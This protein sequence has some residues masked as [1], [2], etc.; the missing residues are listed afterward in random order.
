MA[1]FLNQDYN[2][3]ST[4]ILV[5][6]S[7]S[8]ESTQFSSKEGSSAPMLTLESGGAEEIS[9]LD[10]NLSLLSSSELIGFET[11]EGYAAGTIHQQ[12]SSSTNDWLINADK[13]WDQEVV[14]GVNRPFQLANSQAFR[15]SN[16]ENHPNGIN[17]P[18][19]SP[20]VQ[21]AGE[22]TSQL[23]DSPLTN[24]D[25]TVR[26]QS[27]IARNLFVQDFWL[28][29]ASSAVDPGLEADIRLDDGQTRTMTLLKFTEVNGK[30]MAR[31]RAYVGPLNVWV[32][33]TPWNQSR[34]G[35]FPN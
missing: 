31:Y 16:R 4:F 5:R 13:P 22:K 35:T 15:F 34:F 7:I 8:D 10:P 27:I 33:L 1:R 12:P 25:G 26:V 20:K 3:V 14:L 17:I 18:I 6:D 23:V 2:R 11:A 30:L 28:R 29:S 32:R 9:L 19:R 24:I 21:P